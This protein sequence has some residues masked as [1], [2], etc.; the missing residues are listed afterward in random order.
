MGKGAQVMQSAVDRLKYRARQ[1][2]SEKESRDGMGVVQREI[3]QYIWL[4]TGLQWYIF[5]AR[6]GGS[7]YRNEAPFQHSTI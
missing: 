1:G 4:F 6:V 3:N 7:V 2:R 5:S